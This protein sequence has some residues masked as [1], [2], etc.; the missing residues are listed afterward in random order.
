PEEHAGPRLVD[1]P[2]QGAEGAI[3]AL[4]VQAPSHA[5]TGAVELEAVKGAAETTVLHR[6]AVAQV[7]AEVRTHGVQDGDG[8]AR[9]AEGDELLPHEL[10]GGDAPRD[11]LLRAQRGE[12]ARG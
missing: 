6:A 8:A 9:V 7:G 10:E 3:P 2:G 5:L 11:H 12:P 4:G 1:G